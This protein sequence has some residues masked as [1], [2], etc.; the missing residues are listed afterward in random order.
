RISSNPPWIHAG[1]LDNR[2]LVAG[3]RLFI[4]V[5]VPGALFQVGDGQAAQGHGEVDQTA[6]ETS[7]PR[8]GRGK[9]SQGEEA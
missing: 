5:H 9:G 6:I 8:G 3:T 2:E 7:L 4:P 1:N